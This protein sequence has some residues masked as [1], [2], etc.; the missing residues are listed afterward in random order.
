[1]S[2]RVLPG[3]EENPEA[4]SKADWGA[5]ARP[6]EKT[7]SFLFLRL[8]ATSANLGPGF[9][10]VAL[11]L[12][13]YVEVEARPALAFEIDASGRDAGICSALTGNL[14]LDTYADVWKR[15]GTGT[16]RPLH[17]TVRN[18]IPLGMG[19]GSSAASRLAGIALANHFA[20]LGWD[21]ARML[22]EAAALEQH[23][24]NVAACCLGGFAV[25]ATLSSRFA[26]Q[27][28]APHPAG[29]EAVSPGVQALSLV[30][31]HGWHALL[32]LPG[33]SLATAASRAV[34]PQ[35]YARAEVVGNLQS[36]S[37]LVAAF[38]TG[39][40]SL[41]QAATVDRLHQ[42][43]R[44]EA[45]PLLPRLL[46]LAGQN[47]IMSVTLSGAGSGVL[48]LLKDEA[49]IPD[50]TTRVHAA[51]GDLI[52]GTIPIAEILPCPLAHEGAVLSA[53]FSRAF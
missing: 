45:C 3:S 17:L 46:P 4:E 38:A 12:A 53:P 22:N 15:H 26:E 19:C 37:L 42:P 1:M 14:L 33:R 47:G 36:L 27:A 5:G 7:E 9:D 21:R 43:Y 51:A 25:A 50:A 18:G 6:R 44:G 35:S 52:Q 34:L 23:P 41:L 2:G 31:P 39:D 32:V 20:G 13:L 28:A 24:D 48:L 11:A 49:A 30:P 10:A 29:R 8:P 40:S 16:P